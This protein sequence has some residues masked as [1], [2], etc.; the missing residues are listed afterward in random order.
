MH[1]ARLGAFCGALTFLV[2]C[3]QDQRPVMSDSEGTRPASIDD[4]GVQVFPATED[5]DGPLEV[6][7]YDVSDFDK[8]LPPRHKTAGEADPDCRATSMDDL[9]YLIA[10]QVDPDSWAQNGGRGRCKVYRR[11][12]L[13]IQQSPENHERIAQ[14]FKALRAVGPR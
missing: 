6:R 7:L 10:D 2:S 1:L 13:F 11:T 8:P 14:L 12:T 9:L 5:A 4:R 3:Q